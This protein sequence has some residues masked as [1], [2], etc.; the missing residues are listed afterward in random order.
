WTPGVAQGAM[1]SG[2][3]A[4]K[5]IAAEL[6]AAERSALA[7]KRDAFKYFD[8][9]TMATIGRSKAVAELGPK[10]GG[11][12][13]AGLPAWLMWSLIHVAFLVGFRNKAMALAEWVWMYFFHER[14]VRLITGRDAMPDAVRPRP[15]TRPDARAVEAKEESEAPA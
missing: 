12:R 4:G 10:F 3:H 1:Q 2:A 9:G 8:K 7:P 6:R 11:S 14:G 13:W 15:D 5:A